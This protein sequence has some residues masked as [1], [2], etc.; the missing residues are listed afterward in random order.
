MTKLKNL[1]ELQFKIQ[2]VIQTKADLM[3]IQ[4][5][6]VK[7]SSLSAADR[8]KVYQDGYFI[9]LSESLKDDF[10]RVQ[11]KLEKN[12]FADLIKSF[13]LTHPS[14]VRNLAEYSEDFLNYIQ[15]NKNS[16]YLEGVSD[17]LEVLSSYAQQPKDQLSTDEIQN[18][19]PFL[20]KKS[21]STCYLK[22]KTQY[23]I[24]FSNLDSIQ[25]EF[26]DEFQFSFLKLLETE[27]TLH[28]VSAYAQENALTEKQITDLVFSWIKKRIIYCKK[29]KS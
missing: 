18:G 24:A 6:I 5:E 23:V 13:I 11:N 2:Q 1:S 22:I 28:E 14:K 15:I 16:V 8:I 12:E 20:V 19:Q 10:Q 9:R 17:W 7:T 25:T 29:Y 21:P 26:I 27:K 4:N 3:E